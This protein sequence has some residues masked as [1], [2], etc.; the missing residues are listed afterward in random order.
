MKK[1]RKKVQTQNS[2]VHPDVMNASISHNLCAVVPPP[3]PG[4]ALIVAQQQ[5]QHAPSLL[6]T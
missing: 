2:A 5:Q 6:H 4:L 1:K 3:P